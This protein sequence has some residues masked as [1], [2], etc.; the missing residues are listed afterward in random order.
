MPGYY[1]AVPLG[2]RGTTPIA[3]FEL[4]YVDAH[5]QASDGEFQEDISQQDGNGVRSSAS[6]RTSMTSPI[7]RITQALLEIISAG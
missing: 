5:E 6:S 1:L 3:I 7:A 4:P 2:Q